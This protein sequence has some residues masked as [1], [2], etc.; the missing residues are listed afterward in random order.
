MVEAVLRIPAPWVRMVGRVSYRF[1]QHLQ[2]V[3]IAIC[4]LL[5]RP[6]GSE[7]ADLLLLLTSAV[8]VIVGG[9]LRSWA[10]GY[11]T[12][13]RQHGGRP[14]RTLVTAGP[15]AHTRNPLYLGSFLIGCG[16][17]AMSGWLSVFLGFAGL[18]VASHYCIIRWEEG[19]LTEEFGSGFLRYAAE[20]PRLFPGL[21][22][23]AVR[24]G[25]FSFPIM[26][27]C[28]EPMKTIGALLV[29]LVMAYFRSRG[30][31]LAA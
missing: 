26:M 11:H 3:L 24:I 23:S 7:R 30:W 5:A 6:L 10:M 31:S 22:S 28:L 2:I 25:S 15:Y 4:L 9:S 1:R 18:F 29:I 17:A 8:L 16:L 20:V 14:E 27:R 21:R 19:R 13:R 12:W